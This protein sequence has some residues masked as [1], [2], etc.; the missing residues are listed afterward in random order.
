MRQPRNTAYVSEFTR[1][2]EGF[3][4]EHP[5]VVEDQ[6]Q[7]RA[8]WWDRKL[9]LEELKKKQASEVRQ[10]G[11]EYFSNPPTCVPP[12]DG[13]GHALTHVPQGV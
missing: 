3:L 11:Y 1:L 13:A 2:M 8:M 6:Q 7:G 4:A 10:K 9:D 5:E 12:P